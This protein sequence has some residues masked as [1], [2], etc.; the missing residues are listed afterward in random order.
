MIGNQVA[1]PSLP[2]LLSEDFKLQ[3]VPET[4]LGVRSHQEEQGQHTQVLIKWK[5]AP[6]LDSTWED[7]EVITENFL[8]FDLEDKVEILGRGNVVHP[9]LQFTY[10]RRKTKKIS[11]QVGTSSSHEGSPGMVEQQGQNGNKDN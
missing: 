7:F 11:K 10:H 9:P 3:W 6:E 1:S 8:E 2:P 4:I 5:G